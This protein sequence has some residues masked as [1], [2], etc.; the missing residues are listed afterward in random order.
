[1][2]TLSEVAANLNAIKLERAHPRIVMPD[3][4][5]A[6]ANRDL[7]ADLLKGTDIDQAELAGVSLEVGASVL[8]AIASLENEI[9]GMDLIAAV[10]SIWVDGVVLGARYMQERQDEA[11][12]DIAGGDDES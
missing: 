7:V 1:M 8:N 2:P 12:L 11:M 3:Q 5:E 9:D 6:D 4:T 10:G